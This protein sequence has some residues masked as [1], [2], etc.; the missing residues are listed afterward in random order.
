MGTTRLLET[1]LICSLGPQTLLV[2]NRLEILPQSQ[3]TA[4]TSELNKTNTTGAADG[5]P[6]LQRVLRELPLQEWYRQVP[7]SATCPEDHLSN[8]NESSCPLQRRYSHMT[9]RPLVSLDLTVF[10]ES[11]FQRATVSKP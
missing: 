10:K 8:N 11:L 2:G 9:N 1:S 7:A 3:L 6:T 5:N 4:A